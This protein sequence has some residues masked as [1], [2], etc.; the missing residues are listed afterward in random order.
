MS[1]FQVTALVL[2]SGFTLKSAEELSKLLMHHSVKAT[3]VRLPWL[4]R[5]Q[6]ATLPVQRKRV[7]SLVGELRSSMLRPK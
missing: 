5:G 4:S 7:Q 3:L 2:G 1:A 6:D